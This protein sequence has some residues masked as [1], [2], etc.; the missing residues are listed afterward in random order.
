M[1]ATASGIID[2]MANIYSY[3]NNWIDV[4]G[5]KPIGL[6]TLHIE[7]YETPLEPELTWKEEVQVYLQVV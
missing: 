2:Q 1:Y 3:I 5:N 4:S 7:I 6:D